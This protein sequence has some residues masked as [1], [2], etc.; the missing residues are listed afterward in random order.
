VFIFPQ[1]WALSVLTGNRRTKEW[2][3][4]LNRAISEARGAA[5]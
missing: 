3:R 1:W 4:E 2:L 5:E